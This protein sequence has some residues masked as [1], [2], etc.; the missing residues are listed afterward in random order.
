MIVDAALLVFFFYRTLSPLC[1]AQNGIVSDRFDNGF[2]VVVRLLKDLLLLQL[3]TTMESTSRFTN[4]RKGARRPTHD[5]H[6]ANYLPFGFH[7]TICLAIFF[8]TSATFLLCL[9]PLLRN[10]RTTNVAGVSGGHSEQHYD[11]LKPAFDP[12]VSTYNHFPTPRKI[13]A[14][15][16]KKRVDSFREQEGYTDASIL[17]NAAAEY[18]RVREQRAEADEDKDDTSSSLSYYLARLLENAMGSSYWE[19]TAVERACYRGFL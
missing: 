8:V 18:L 19:C 6:F 1:P 17:R 10:T 4:R 12:L 7:T 16:V 13:F 3:T 9:V 2:K 15:A 14:E 11:A 5:Q